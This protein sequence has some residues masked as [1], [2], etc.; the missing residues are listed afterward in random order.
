MKNKFFVVVI[1]IITIAL[2]NIGGLSAQ[3]VSSSAHNTGYVA[4]NSYSG[5]I[6][7]SLFTFRIDISGNNVNYPNWSLMVRANP[8]I[9]NSEGKRMDP[10]KISLRLNRVERGPTI[11]MMGTS[12]T[13]VPLSFSNKYLIQRSNSPIMPPAGTDNNQWVFVF[14]VIVQGGSYLETLKSWENYKLNLTFTVL[15]ESNGV[16]TES[17]AGVDMQLH[18]QDMPPSEP[19]YGIE[20][21]SNARNGLLEFKTMSDYVNGVSQIY[22]NGL[23][24]TSTTSY[25]VQVRSLK[26]NFEADAN[27]LPVSTVSLEIKD[28]NNSGVGGTKPLSENDQTVFRATNPDKKARLYNIR[29]F[30]QPNDERMIYAK[31]ASYETTLVYTLVPQ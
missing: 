28:P 11:Q 30:T 12:K 16:L 13:P 1:V 27:T 15:N 24:V 2:F 6:T 7:E 31:P 18:P 4:L 14:D 10:S 26:N 22:Q 3:G 19:T 29:Y 5:K 9:T 23:S 20:I 25:A 8:L 21:N 17:N